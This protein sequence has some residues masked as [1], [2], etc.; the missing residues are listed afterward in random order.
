MKYCRSL[1]GE[2]VELWIPNFW[3]RLDTQKCADRGD[4]ALEKLNDW[5][6]DA[7]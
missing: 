1:C 2:T 4:L 7:V 3:S 6:S 5:P